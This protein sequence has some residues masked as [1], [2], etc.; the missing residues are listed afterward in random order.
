[1]FD[2]NVTCGEPA[3][4]IALIFPVIECF[5]IAGFVMAI[6]TC[7]LTDFSYV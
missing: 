5:H 3:Q 4:F 2:A 1:V 7:A 6:G